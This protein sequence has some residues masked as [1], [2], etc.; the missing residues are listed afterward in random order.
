MPQNSALLQ[1][2]L[3]LEVVAAL[4]SQKP[5]G[6]DAVH[7]IVGLIEACVIH[8][9]IWVDLMSDT[10]GGTIPQAYMDHLLIKGL[11]NL[12]NHPP[13]LAIWFM[14]FE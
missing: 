3:I 10:G 11:L 6:P 5:A 14:I 7:A 9:E 1:D 13:D 4:E 2:E 8:E 12:L